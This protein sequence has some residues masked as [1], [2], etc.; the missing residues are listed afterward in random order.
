MLN[1][2]IVL[3]YLRDCDDE[4]D[5]GFFNCG[6]RVERLRHHA[7][8]RGD[9]ENSYVRC[10]RAARTK[11]LERLVS[12]CVKKSNL[13]SIMDRDIG[14]DMLGDAARFARDD[15]CLPDVIQKRRLPM[16]Y[17]AHHRDDGR[18]RY[19]FHKDSISSQKSLTFNL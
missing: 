12:G 15:I 4:K 3:V 18:P 7:F 10:R 16:V 1:I 6:E 13:A 8:V 2:C 11:R 14:G 5:A 17:V 9:D 19:P